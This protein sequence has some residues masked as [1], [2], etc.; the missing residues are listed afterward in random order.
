MGD[1]SGFWIFGGKCDITEWCCLSRGGQ[2]QRSIGTDSD[3]EAVLKQGE[4]CS[5]S[6]VVR[7]EWSPLEM[8]GEDVSYCA[9]VKIQLMLEVEGVV[10]N[11]G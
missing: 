11:V 7:T 5:V 1:Y 9:K 2:T 10:E 3:L 6:Q 8:M 4:R